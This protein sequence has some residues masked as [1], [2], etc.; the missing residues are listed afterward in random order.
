[1]LSWNGGVGYPDED[2]TVIQVSSPGWLLLAWYW[3]PTFCF[4]YD[5]ALCAAWS[6]ACECDLATIC[7]GT[8]PTD[9]SAQGRGTAYSQ[10]VP[11]LTQ[12]EHAGVSKSQPSF[13]CAHARQDFRLDTLTFVADFAQRRLC[14]SR[15]SPGTTTLAFQSSRGLSST[16]FLLPLTWSC[17]ADG[18]SVEQEPIWADKRKPLTSIKALVTD[19]AYMGRIW[20]RAGRCRTAMS[21]STFRRSGCIDRLSRCCYARVFLCT[22]LSCHR[23]VGFCSQIPRKTAGSKLDTNWDSEWVYCIY[24]PIILYRFNF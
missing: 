6:A 15:R 12:R 23:S 14:R 5:E 9:V 16:S 11:R 7:F 21:P 22:G 19:A 17:T 24:D 3:Y 2:G 8:P 13:D 4:A 18:T 1:M 20:R 10:F